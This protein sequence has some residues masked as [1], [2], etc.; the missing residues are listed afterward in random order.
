MLLRCSLECPDVVAQVR[1]TPPDF[2]ATSAAPQRRMPASPATIRMDSALRL[3]VRIKDAD[4][5][6][7]E[8]RSFDNAVLY[9]RCVP[10]APAR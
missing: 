2:V 4:S 6:V 9:S 10:Y 1:T 8:M 3:A 5:Q 7:N